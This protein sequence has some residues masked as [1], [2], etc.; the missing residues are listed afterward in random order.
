MGQKR[1][2]Q[3]RM[4]QTQTQFIMNVFRTEWGQTQTQTVTHVYGVCARYR[5]FTE[6]NGGVGGG[7]EQASGI[8]DICIV[9]ERGERRRREKKEERN[10]IK[11]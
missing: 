1:M 7:R 2:G 9:L 6:Q 8:V 5:R 4:G 3:E 10:K 11:G